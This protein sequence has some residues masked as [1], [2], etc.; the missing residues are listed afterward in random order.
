MRQDARM[1]TP[2]RI[3]APSPRLIGAKRV[4]DEYGLN[5]HGQIKFIQARAKAGF[6]IKTAATLKGLYAELGL[7]PSGRC[8]VSLS[9]A[10][11]ASKLDQFLADR[12]GA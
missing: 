10:R 8:R 6:L 3:T 11:G 1:A 2:K 7:S 9:P 12:H 4:P 5:K